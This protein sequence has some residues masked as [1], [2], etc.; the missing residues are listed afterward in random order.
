MCLLELSFVLKGQIYL[1][2]L[3]LVML[4]INIY[5]TVTPL[6]ELVILS[7]SASEYCFVTMKDLVISSSLQNFSEIIFYHCYLQSRKEKTVM[8]H[9]SSA[10]KKNCSKLPN[11]KSLASRFDKASNQNWNSKLAWNHSFF[12]QRFHV[13]FP[14]NISYFW[15][16]QTYY[17][18]FGYFFQQYCNFS[19]S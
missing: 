11:M 19:F 14:N 4:I 10:S 9:T 3:M 13:Y 6:Q 16:C 17:F 5:L 12:H 8:S 7:K 2:I 1:T 15:L 18:N